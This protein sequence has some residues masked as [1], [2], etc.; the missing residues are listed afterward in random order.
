[1]EIY[2]DDQF[3][4][5]CSTFLIVSSS[6]HFRSMCRVS[7]ARK[8]VSTKTRLHLLRLLIYRRVYASTSRQSVCDSAPPYFVNFVISYLLC[9]KR[10]HPA[11]I[12]SRHA[13][14][15]SHQTNL[16]FHISAYL[17]NFISTQNFLNRIYSSVCV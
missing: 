8:V 17:F 5:C 15:S 9:F 7:N 14:L 2:D 4:V 12:I 1:M 16:F 10:L 3:F 6:K 11:P 13:I